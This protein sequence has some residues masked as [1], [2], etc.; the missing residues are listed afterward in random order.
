MKK[1]ILLALI[2][3]G[4]YSQTAPLVDILHV[5]PRVFVLSNAHVHTEPGKSI[6][7]ASI[8]IRDGLIMDVGSKIE[9][10]AD[11]TVLDME[12]SDIYA[13]FI[14][15]WVEVETADVQKTSRSHWNDLVHPQWVASDYY[16]YDESTVH[17]LHSQGFTQIHAV[18]DDGIFRG[19]SS[20]I[21]LN[22]EASITAPVVSQVMDYKVREPGSIEYPRALLGTI[23]VMRQTLYDAEWYAESQD[24][25][26]KYPDKNEPITENVALDVLGK[27][28]ANKAPFLI[29]T[30][31]ETAATRAIGF[32]REFDLK[33]WLMG[34]GY[35][36]RRLSDIT[37]ANP[38]IVLP[39]NFPGKPDITNP[40]RALQYTTAELKHWDMAPDNAQKLVESGLSIAFTTAGLKSHKQF[41]ENLIMSVQR[42]LSES[43]ALAALTTNPAKRFGIS[44]THG[45]IKA[46][47]HA[48]FVVVDGSYFDE[49]NAIKAV[50]V[51]GIKYDIESG[52]EYL[53]PGKWDYSI[54][55]MTGQLE[56]KGKPSKLSGSI[57]MDTGTID[58][59]HLKI[60][61]NQLTWSATLNAE[62]FPGVTRFSGK[63]ENFEL[64]GF[65]TNSHGD[66]FS[67]VGTNFKA[68][69][70]QKS[71]K[72]SP[73]SLSVVYP[74][75]AYGFE[76]LPDQPHSIFINDATIWTSGPRGILKDWDM[77]ITDGK[78]SKIAPELKIPSNNDVLIEGRGKFV[79]AGIIDAHS[80]TAAASINEGAQTVTSEVRI[81]DVLVPD[82]ISIYRQLAGGTTTIN[83]L[84]GSGNPIGGHNAV[85]KL[86]WG[87]NGEGLLLQGAAP[88]IKFALGENVKYDRYIKRYPQT[89][90]GVEQ[91]IR[92]AFTR[93]RDYKQNHE[94]YAKKSKWRKT[95]IPPR[96]DLELDALVEVLDGKRYIN[97]H[98]YRQDEILMLLRV[99]ED[100]DFT[101]AKFEHV[102]E[103]YK[104]AEK[105]AEHGAGG[106]S[107][108]DWWAYKFET[109]DGIP[110]NGALMHEAG[111]LVSFN[112][113]DDEIARRLNL[114]AAKGIKFGGMSEIDA[115]NMVTI[116]SA[117]QLKIDKWVGSLEEGKDADFVIWSGHPLSTQSICT[118]TWIDGRQYFSLEKDAELRTRDQSIRQDLI[119]KIL[120][121]EDDGNSTP[122]PPS[123][124][125]PNQNINESLSE[126]E[127]VGQGGL[128]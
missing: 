52:S 68:K 27:A 26:A 51:R 48:N 39:L 101:V 43:A 77:L 93:A 92:D 116:N 23:A 96:K 42:G 15:G 75:G 104:V 53:L 30:E 33:L 18:I 105:L 83:V 11:A 95:L 4:L 108:A 103:G 9:F 34:S 89:R 44:N 123:P 85:I 112:S 80:H 125:P 10:P 107:F 87:S 55:G 100:F 49:A 22:A 72:A 56:I 127:R 12:G 99:A 119:Q 122:D 115:L 3:G 76:K 114:E 7:Q 31:H 79:T 19:Q 118:E 54:H 71:I 110:Y 64:M 97:A 63:I 66:K 69:E 102:L 57:T 1:S 81:Q 35:E 74:E 8:V 67:F 120:R 84:H 70:D 13:G 58:L 109:Y 113:D 106:S 32:A 24:I 41:R 40:M 124:P 128:R 46:G 121:S 91:I 126:D 16:S 111:V 21:D 5:N 50:W 6:T 117:K 98:A 62:D 60:D 17:D 82:D 88:G 73:S 20:I 29:R 61:G 45:I 65:A 25:Y 38:F 37:Q 86:R 28:R 14:D 78:I 47:Y 2:A 36:Y 94:A 90:M 59:K